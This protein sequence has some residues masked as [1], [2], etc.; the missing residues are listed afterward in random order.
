[1][2]ALVFEK[3]SIFERIHT[4]GA[5]AVLVVVYVTAADTVKNRHTFRRLGEL[6][7][8]VRVPF[9]EFAAGRPCGVRHPFELH[10]G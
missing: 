5:R 6:E 1:V 4:A 3:M 7:T 8:V 9:K 10:V 2:S